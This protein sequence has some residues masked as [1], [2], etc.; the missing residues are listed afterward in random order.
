M[1]YSLEIFASSFSVTGEKHVT[2]S[3]S[4]NTF[5]H[6]TDKGGI[7]SSPSDHWLTFE[8]FCARTVLL[9]SKIESEL[10]C[11]YGRTVIGDEWIIWKAS[12]IFETKIIEYIH[13]QFKPQDWPILLFPANGK[14]SELARIK[15]HALSKNH[16]LNIFFNKLAGNGGGVQG[17]YIGITFSDK[18]LLIHFQDCDAVDYPLNQVVAELD[19]NE[20]RFFNNI[21]IQGH[22]LSGFSI[23]FPS[24][25]IAQRY[26]KEI[27]RKEVNGDSV[28]FDKNSEE[29]LIGTVIISGVLNGTYVENKQCGVNLKKSSLSIFEIDNSKALCSFDFKSKDL[30][31]DG[32][33][34]SFLVSSSDS[35][36]LKIYSN[37][38]GFLNAI[39]NNTAVQRAAIRSSNVGP[40]IAEEA[41]GHF[42]RFE[43]NDS[44]L[45]LS[46]TGDNKQEISSE[47]QTPELLIR[48]QTPYLKIG[49]CEFFAGLGTLEGIAA[50]TTA[51]CFSAPDVSNNFEKLC[52]AM[53]GMEGQFLAYCI[54]GDLA[55]TQIRF[56]RAIGLEETTFASELKG[57]QD[58]QTFLSI[59]ASIAGPFSR[60]LEETIHYL[61]S[62]ILARDVEF[63]SK[64]QLEKHLNSEKAENGY[65]QA[66]SPCLS[67]VNHLVRIDG[68]AARFSSLQGN[69]TKQDDMHKL[70]PLGATIAVGLFHPLM[71]VGAI[72]QVANLKSGNKM[73][74]A[75]RDD[76]FREAINS[77]VTSGI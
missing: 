67:L 36:S 63:L 11:L 47:T 30:A 16:Q 76:S 44:H 7:L 27:P 75:M 70:V 6:F 35:L 77:D 71:W 60:G 9:S 50:M 49:E 55:E 52:S 65:L 28:A 41:S 53:L 10:Q 15:E 43:M 59:M 56:S 74:D 37:D 31:I 51:K 26:Y 69:L 17:T 73:K 8:D 18:Q 40:F 48:N 45:T 3:E 38:V 14:N 5:F 21:L 19:N 62:F 66:V 72:N 57:T 33:S 4:N 20:I 2:I 54:F 32:T 1:P 29:G 25:T 23:I 39:V 42:V 13:S 61:P 24:A 64:A 22:Q 58:Q 12:S 46:F 68:I 34:E